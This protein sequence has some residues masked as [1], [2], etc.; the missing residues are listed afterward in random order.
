MVKDYSDILTVFLI[1]C[2][3]N[4]NYGD[5]VS[6]LKKQSICFGT[7]EI[8]DVKPLSLAFQK[9]IDNCKTKYYIEIDEDMIMRHDSIE[10]MLVA[11]I[12][13]EKRDDR[14]AMI[15]FKLNDVHSG[16]DIYGVKIY[17]HDILKNYPYDLRHPSCE[18]EQIARFKNDGYVNFLSSDVVGEHSPKWN[19]E[20][21]Y[22]RY[23][24]LMRKFLIYRYQWLENIPA[25]LIEK[26]IKEPNREN[27]FALLGA[28]QGILDGNLEAEKDFSSKNVSYMKFKPFFKRPNQATL[29][30]TSKCNFQCNFCVRQHG[31]IEQA[32]DMTVDTVGNLLFKFPTIIGVCVCGFGEPLLA[33]NLIPILQCLKERKMFVGLITNG[34]LLN[35]RF[36]ALKEQSLGYISVSL[37]AWNAD[38]HEATTKTKTWEEVIDGIKMVVDY[39]K[40][41]LYVSYVLTK[42]NLC[43]VE[44]IIELVGKLGVSNVHFHNILPHFDENENGKFDELVLTK[45]D[46]DTIETLKSLDKKNIVKRWPILIDGSGGNNSCNF[47]YRSIQ[48]NGNGNLGLCNS[49][50]PCNKKYG[51]IMDYVVWNSESMMQFREDY[52][53]KQIPQCK[54]CFRNWICD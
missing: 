22:D 24:N 52:L 17:R 31:G 40:I 7:E 10:K 6:A 14:V 48:I 15:S 5:C 38:M 36:D 54:R 9:M 19:N 27:I 4:P 43:D 42:K 32:P 26:I 53:Y 49:V 39:K 2:G 35:R 12:D 8:K 29:Y 11:M 37:N 25:M 23:N 45:D 13:C 34:S 30:V 21:I 44:H 41:T 1:S 3:S 51:N 28:Y 46:A 18:V 50:I 16:Q 47:P 33:D 20:L